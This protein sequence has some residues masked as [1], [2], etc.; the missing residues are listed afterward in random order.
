[1]VTQKVSTWDTLQEHPIAKE[2]DA[3]T[4]LALLCE[5]IDLYEELQGMTLADFVDGYFAAEEQVETQ[6]DAT[7]T[8]EVEDEAAD[9]SNNGDVVEAEA[10]DEDAEVPRPASMVGMRAVYR[11]PGRNVL[12]DEKGIIRDAGGTVTFNDVDGEPWSN[13]AR[14]RV[15][16]INP[17]N[18]HVI[19]VAPR[20]AKEMIAW[21]D[22]APALDEPEGTVLRN[23]FV[24]FAAFPDRITFA[25]MNA[26]RPFV[27]RFVALPNNGFEDDQK[28][29][30][31]LFGE[32]CFRVRK[33][34]HVVNVMSP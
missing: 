2:L 19:H 13:V 25:V 5:F 15:Y 9:E 28:P 34:D 31:R 3:D 18:Y 14:E 10:E 20:E 17:K 4:K 26:K 16:P 21:L 33:K 8:A 23:L 12:S 27:D 22:G 1:M 6:A 24:E 32:H 29:T 11:F 30:T 7:D